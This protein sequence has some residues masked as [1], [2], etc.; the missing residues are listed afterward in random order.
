MRRRI[1][2]TPSRSWSHCSNGRVT[3]TYS[4]RLQ[5][6]L[7][8]RQTMVDRI[9]LEL[10]RIEEERMKEQARISDLQQAESN[11]LSSLSREVGSGLGGVEIGQLAERLDMLQTS[12]LEHVSV[13]RRL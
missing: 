3:M 2:T 9:W 10:S 5:S 1:S 7:D 6:V 11:T 13:L 8:Y 4:F 12:I